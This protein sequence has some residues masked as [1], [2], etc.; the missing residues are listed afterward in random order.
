ML[1]NQPDS[2]FYVHGM[3]IVRFVPVDASLMHTSKFCLLALKSHCLVLYHRL[4][5]KTKQNWQKHSI[6]EFFDSSLTF[7]FLLFC[8]C[9]DVVS[10]AEVLLLYSGCLFV[11]WRCCR[12]TVS[13]VRC[14]VQYFVVHE[15]VVCWTPVCQYHTSISI[16]RIVAESKTQGCHIFYLFNLL[17]CMCLQCFDAVGWV[18]DRAS[19]L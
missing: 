19:G 6:I 8:H 12:S 2:W 5:L 18:A 15:I 7:L 11:V 3:F 13:Y 14:S 4:W 10:Q 1:R 9:C 16:V 17:V